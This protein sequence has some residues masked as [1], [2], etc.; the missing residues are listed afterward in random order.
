MPVFSTRSD[1]YAPFTRLVT[2]GCMRAAKNCKRIALTLAL[3]LGMCLP[4]WAQKAIHAT[5]RGSSAPLTSALLVSDEWHDLTRRDGSGL[6]FELVRTVFE[7]Q[8]VK[9]QFRTFPY[10]RA[11]QKVRDQEADGWVASFLNEKNFPLYPKYHFDKNEQIIVFRKDQQEEPVTKASLRNKRVAWLRDFGLDRF[12]QEPM[13]VHEV[14]SIDSAFQMLERE[15]IDYFVG[16][17]SDIQDHIRN[18]RQDMSA[19]GMAYAL[20][21]GLYVAFADN[22]R[23]KKLRAMWDKEMETFHQSEAI[24]EIYRKYGYPYPFP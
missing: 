10:A 2:A 18:A 13:R 24:K 17:K 20:H 1:H 8:G 12:I 3:T 7:R 15:R 11:V 14:D 22:T 23:G 4:V 5:Q 21:L 19:F 6:Y 16:A 9:V